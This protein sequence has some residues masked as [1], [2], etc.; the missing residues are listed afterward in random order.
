MPRVIW[1]LPWHKAKS[2]RY[3]EM[4]DV[5][6]IDDLT[7]T[8]NHVKRAGILYKI[9]LYIN[10]SKICFGLEPQIYILYVEKKLNLLRLLNS[11]GVMAMISKFV[12]W[13]SIRVHYIRN[14]LPLK[15]IV[16]SLTLPEF[17]FFNSKFYYQLNNGGI[18]LN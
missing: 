10:A 2:R 3:P 5:D 8:T 12:Q 16:I 13:G 4:I 15:S 11:W 14:M 6:H 1:V 7:I 18:K 9:N 17:N